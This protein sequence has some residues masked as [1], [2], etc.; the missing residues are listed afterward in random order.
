MKRFENILN[1]RR[2]RVRDR[3][4][5]REIF[6]NSEER[7]SKN[8]EIMVEFRENNVEVLFE[9]SFG[10]GEIFRNVFSDASE[11]GNFVE[12]GERE[13]RDVLEIFS[14]EFSDD[15]G[16]DS[17]GFSFAKRKI[18]RKIFDEDRIDESDLFFERKNEA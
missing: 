5:S 4:R 16:V 8:I 3:L 9:T 6:E 15:V 18:L 7:V 14:D 1:R 11:S 12:I 17:I 2:M 13:I 10:F